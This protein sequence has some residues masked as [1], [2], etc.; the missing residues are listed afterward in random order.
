MLNK[1]D[2]WSPKWD[3]QLYI[4]SRKYEIFPDYSPLRAA[5]KESRPF[6]SWNEDYLRSP[7]N[8][9]TNKNDDW[10]YFKK[11]FI[12]KPFEIGFPFGGQGS[13]SESKFIE[14]YELADLENML[15]SQWYDT[16]EQGKKA[17]FDRLPQF[18][19]IGFW[20]NSID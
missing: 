8:M 13:K 4:Y 3:D 9:C 12:S 5:V 10:L 11:R 1:L 18:E 7:L 6:I 17:N 19:S 2:A 20:P 14:T 15:L 16:L